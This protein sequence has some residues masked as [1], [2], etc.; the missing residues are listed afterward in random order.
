VE[1][2]PNMSD[3]D[4][5]NAVPFCFDEAGYYM[6]KS[7]HVVMDEFWSAE[8]QREATKTLNHIK[9]RGRKK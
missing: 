5:S 7:P 3:A 8:M 9:N 1:A 2:K 6:T 4:A